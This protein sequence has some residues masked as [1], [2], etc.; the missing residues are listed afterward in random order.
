MDVSEDETE[1]NKLK[2][3][4][5]NPPEPQS[6]DANKENNDMDVSEDETETNKPNASENNA[7]EPQ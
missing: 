5:N 7:P 1:T 2:A 6:S 4:E 3:S